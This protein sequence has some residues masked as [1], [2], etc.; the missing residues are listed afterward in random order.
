VIRSDTDFKVIQRSTFFSVRCCAAEDQDTE[1]EAGAQGLLLSLQCLDA[2]RGE[3][4]RQ[5]WAQSLGIRCGGVCF[6]LG[7]NP[8]SDEAFPSKLFVNP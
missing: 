4:V 2:V 6:G 7:F 3:Q 1:G 8:V 5:V